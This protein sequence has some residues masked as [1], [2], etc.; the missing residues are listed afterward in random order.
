M[1]LELPAGSMADLAARTEGWVAGL[2]LAGLSLRGHADPVR[3]VATF[4]ASHR[5]ILEYLS[6]EV[7]ARQPEHVVGLL[8]AVEG[9]LDAAE[10]AFAAAADEPYQPSVGKAASL[11]ANI[12]ATIA[13]DRA[14]LPLPARLGCGL[15]QAHIH[16]KSLRSRIDAIRPESS[17]HRGRV[18][19][20]DARQPHCR[21]SQS[22]P[23]RM[24]GVLL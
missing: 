24:F 9:P 3:F 12:P 17:V 13:L 4:S 21:L 15:W 16:I 20:G 14:F 10:R 22:R 5:Y 7:L 23:R 2:Q 11:S 18:Q 19:A 6:E 1:E 8:E